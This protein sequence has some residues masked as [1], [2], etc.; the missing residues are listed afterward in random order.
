MTYTFSSGQVD[1]LSV[2]LPPRYARSEVT[3]DNVRE[4]SPVGSRQVDGEDW[5]LVEVR[6]HRP[7][8]SGCRIELHWLA[9]L[10]ALDKPASLPLPQAADVG[11]ES[12]LV[13]L[14]AAGGLSL[15]TVD[16]AG[17]RRAD[18]APTDASTLSPQSPVEVARYYWPY[19]P[20]AIRVELRRQTPTIQARLRQLVR[21]AP[22]NVQL[23]A[24]VELEAANGRLFS[25]SFA[26]PDGYELL[27]VLG[28]AVVDYYVQPTPQG[29][30]LHVNLTGA[31]RTRLA[32][33]MVR[34]SPP[35][36]TLAAPHVTLIASDGTPLPQEGMQAVQV[37]AALVPDVRLPG[38]AK[39]SVHMS[40]IGSR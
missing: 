1:R 8:A 18:T 26:L 4:V 12:G 27:S 19:R 35:A 37:A 20:F 33:A 9:D 16:V 6:L 32:L 29:R 34:T 25:S 15:R 17:G 39:T 21:V 28:P 5:S 13:A 22:D 40:I 7:A 10:P 24:D 11:R 2:L 31:D 30:R 14:F 38:T 36:G 3:G 23:L